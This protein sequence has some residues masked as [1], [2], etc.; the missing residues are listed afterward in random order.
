MRS[1]EHA[2]QKRYK[3][4]HKRTGDV[5]QSKGAIAIMGKADPKIGRCLAPC[6]LV[7][8]PTQMIGV[9]TFDAQVARDLVS[10]VVRE[11]LSQGGSYA[12]P[13]ARP[14]IWPAN[15][16]EEPR[17]LVDGRAHAQLGHRG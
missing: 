7:S 3:H 12:T 17:I 16:A 15:I 6:Y 2:S 8:A 1:P 10:E 14:A 5:I 13:L 4:Y 9:F 11:Q